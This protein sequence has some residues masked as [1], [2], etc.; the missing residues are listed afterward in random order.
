M[1]QKIGAYTATSTIEKLQYCALDNLYLLTRRNLGNTISLATSK[2]YVDSAIDEGMTL[3]LQMH[4]LVASPAAATEW[5]ITDF[6]ALVD[7]VVSKKNLIEVVTLTEWYKQVTSNSRRLV[8]YQ[9][10]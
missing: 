7:Y 5:A 6:Q 9:Q 4:K 1:A 10:I 3:I 2:G 8:D